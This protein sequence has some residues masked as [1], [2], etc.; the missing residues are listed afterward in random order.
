MHLIL[1]KAILSSMLFVNFLKPLVV[2]NSVKAL[3]RQL[4]MVAATGTFVVLVKN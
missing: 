2:V 3:I 1:C 4:N